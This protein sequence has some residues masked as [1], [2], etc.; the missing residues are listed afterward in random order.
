[1]KEKIQEELEEIYNYDIFRINVSTTG[2][3]NNYLIEVT[4][5]LR[6]ESFNFIYTYDSSMSINWNIKQIE[7]TIDI[8]IFFIFL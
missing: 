8:D 4:F 3:R 2:V 1:M 6:E 5:L 7:N